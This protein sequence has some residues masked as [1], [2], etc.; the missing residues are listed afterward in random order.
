MEASFDDGVSWCSLPDLPNETKRHTQ[1]GL[2]ACGG[3]EDGFSCWTF[4]SGVWNKSH[5]LMNRRDL[6][7]AWNSPIGV[8]LFGGEGGTLWSE[9]LNDDGQSD[10]GIYLDEKVLSSCAIQ[11]DR[12]SCCLVVASFLSPFKPF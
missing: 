2:V 8:M 11:L 4:S 6:H 7:S 9:T 1:S 3:N 5:T 12:S 10:V